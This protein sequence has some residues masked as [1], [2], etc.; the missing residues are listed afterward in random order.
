MTD[1]VRCSSYRPLTDD[2]VQAVHH[3]VLKVLDEVG[4]QVNEAEALQHFRDAGARIKD[5]NVVCFAPD[6]VMELIGRAPREPIL[7]GREE[8]HNVHM[9]K[10]YVNFGTGGTTIR[11]R[12]MEKD[13]VRLSTIADIHDAAKLVDALPNIHLFML[14][15]FPNDLAEEHVDVN[16][17]YAGLLNTR[18]HIMGGI[19]TVEGIRKVIGMAAF[20]AGSAED[21]RKRPFISMITCIISPLKM[22]R[23]YTR[24]MLEVVKAGIP[25]VCPSEPLSGAT[26]P[27]TLAGTMVIQIADSLSGV[28]LSQIVNPGTP[29]IFGTV[30]S[31]TDLRDMKYLCGSI[32]MGLLSAAEAQMAQFYGLPFYAVGGMS[33]AKTTDAQCGY[34][35]AM[36]SILNALAGANFVHDAAGMHDFALTWSH[37]KCVI[38]NE[39]IGMAMRAARGIDISEQSLAFDVIRS[40]GP[41]GT[42]ID[43]KHTVKHM[44][45]EHYIPSL[46]DR[47][48]QELWQ[49]KGSLPVS[50]KARFRA[51]EIL[52]AKKEPALTSRIREELHRRFP[53]IVEIPVPLTAK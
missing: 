48:R 9:G 22:D 16:R 38:D 3:T 50:V 53:E 23:H 11:I 42:F 5:D 7:Y 35:S 45:Q 8:K 4:I 13:T 44:R 31:T 25:L 21:L 15:L 27:I 24:L 34:E 41:G 52:A 1:G 33:D 26:S 37:D 17:F 47:D 18:K 51:N 49:E 12:D 6:L 19:Y 46:S 2:G 30:S 43:L 28:L 20:I 10:D 32:E 14:S 39:I 40:V 29:V 36:T